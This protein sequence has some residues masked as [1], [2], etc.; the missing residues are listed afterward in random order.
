MET[1]VRPASGAVTLDGGALLA[2]A[3]AEPYGY[4]LFALLR[5]VECANPGLPLLGQAKRPRDEAVRIGQDPGLAF[6]ASDVARI[7]PA[8]EHRPA[9]L[10]QHVLGLFGPNGALPLHLS[11]Y[12]F[13]RL[14]HAG[15]ATLVRFADVFHHRMLALFYR[16]WA[17][18]QPAVSMDRPALDRFGAWIGALCGLGLPALRN[19]DSVDD[20]VKLAHAAIFGHQVKSAEGLQIVLANYFRVPVR[21]EQWCGQWLDIPRSERTRLGRRDGFAVLGEDV[22]IGERLWDCQSKFRVVLGPLGFDDYQRFLPNGRSYARLADLVRLYVGV[23]LAWELQLVLRQE[24]V[25]LSWLGN[26]VFLGYTSWLGVRLEDRDADELVL[27]GA[28]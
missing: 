13:E 21:V 9:R 14:H 23:E 2:Q 8:A 24:Q 6:A 3:G 27:A 15:D 5:L 19:R 25:P 26:S 4:Q 10:V 12:A 28:G 18:T 22:V 7:E 1:A 17:C 11:E 16:A 20:F